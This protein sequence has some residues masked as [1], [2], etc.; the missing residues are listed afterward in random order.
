MRPASK[1]RPLSAV[2]DEIKTDR[3]ET[4]VKRKCEGYQGYRLS[5]NT[6]LDR[7]DPDSITRA[8]FFR[9]YVA[10]RKPCVIPRGVHHLLKKEFPSLE[11]IEGIVGSDTAVSVERR[12]N[13]TERF[14]QA[15][16]A[17]RQINMTFGAF[18]KLLGDEKI[19][20]RNLFYLTTQY[21]DEEHSKKTLKVSKTESLAM[22]ESTIDTNTCVLREPVHWA[23]PCRQLAQ[24]SILPTEIPWLSNLRLASC[25]AWMGASLQP[26]SSG[27]HHDFH[28][29]L[30]LVL[31]GTK[32]FQLWDPSFVEDMQVAGEVERVHPNGLISYR[33]NPVQADGSP[34]EKKKAEAKSDMDEDEDEDRVGAFDGGAFVDRGYDDEE[35]AALQAALE[36]EDHDD[37]DEEFGNDSEEEASLHQVLPD[38]FSRVSNGHHTHLL[39]S[40]VS[41]T[42]QAGD[43]LYM[44]AS[45]F[46]CVRSSSG[47]Y[48]LAVNYWYHPPDQLDSEDKPYSVMHAAA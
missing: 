32:E 27:L 22:S 5:K 33:N 25:Q 18:C 10:L 46:H 38:N 14:G 47:N 42:L 19:E 26:T 24:A 34:L 12:T 29:N 36:A 39:Q 28:D 4:K 20:E 37:Y 15:K 3:K 43:L 13:T 6:T 21:E 2:T 35:E 23:A 48:H 44:P 30:Y 45:W 40:A 31:N 7:L 17:K 11:T 9:N 16:T 1:K 41:I 8:S